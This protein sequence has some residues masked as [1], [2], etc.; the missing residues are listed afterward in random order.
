MTLSDGAI[1]GYE[2][3]AAMLAER[4]DDPALLKIYDR[5]LA[6]LPEIRDE[7]L[8]LDVGAGAGRDTGWLAGRG[9]QVVAAEPAAGMRAEGMRRHG[10]PTIRWL[11]DRLPALSAVH[12]LG[13]SFDLILLSAVWQHVAPAERPRAF[14]KLVT[15]MKPGALLLVS[16]R[17]GPAPLDRPMFEV[18]L[19]EIEGLARINGL[20]LLRAVPSDDDQ[21]RGDVSW[22]HVVL[23]MPDDGTGALPLIRGIILA[24]DKSSTYKLALLRTVAR[25]A[26]AAP[27]AA[28]VSPGEVDSVEL[29]LGL[30]ALTW[31]RMF[32][33]LVRAGLPQ[34]PKN[35]GPDGLGFAKAGFRGLMADRVAPVDLRVGA[36]FSGDR[37]TSLA[38][39]LSKAA[40]TIT[41]MPANFTCYP[42]SETRVFG[43][44]KARA[45]RAPETLV[46]DLDT[47]RSWGSF[48]VPGHL[49][50]ALT[51]LGSWVE[52]VLI[53]EWA[54]LMRNYGDRM[55]RLIPAGQAEAALAWEEPMRDTALGRS[56][57][58]R[59]TALGHRIDCVWS[60][61]ALNAARLDI[62]HCLPWSAWPCG[63]LWNLLPSD[64]RL[65]Q[66]QK[67][68]RLPSFATMADARPRILS[69]WQQAWLDDPAL[70]PR[71]TREV[72]A[73]LPVDPVPSLEDVYAALEWRRLRLR[74]DQHVPEWTAAH[75]HPATTAPSLTGTGT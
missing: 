34:A 65:N 38:S 75:L 18:S 29:P 49:W 70:G 6:L 47:L 22:T 52:P 4:Y 33:P 46:L 72:A 51:R 71:F 67:R 21:G 62:D 42:S 5:I 43:A 20:E 17:E 68:D 58:A 41:N 2:A 63:D 28:R 48:T 12:A 13:L 1:A 64:R 35:S 23:K 31:I 24:D 15:L 37:S 53:A 32:L 56:A 55:G 3:Q 25:I 73:A 59:L 36:S 9:Y 14:R 66:H 7:R 50:R 11:D 60:G 69:W 40:A 30:V 61:V 44:T 19:G 57:A 54:R 10:G 45:A 39:A 8:A 27:A 16:L 74:Q 26:E